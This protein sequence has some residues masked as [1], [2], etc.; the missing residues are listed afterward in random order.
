MGRTPTYGF[1][2]KVGDLDEGFGKPLEDQ[3]TKMLHT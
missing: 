3:D 2:A 1:E